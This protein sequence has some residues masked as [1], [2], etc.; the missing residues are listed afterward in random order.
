MIEIF[1]E[2]SDKHTQLTFMA[3]TMKKQDTLFPIV[4]YLFFVP[5]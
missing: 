3:I 2:N 4:P 1:I 5:Q